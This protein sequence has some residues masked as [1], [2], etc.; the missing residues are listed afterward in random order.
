MCGGT[1]REVLD[2]EDGGGSGDAEASDRVTLLKIDDQ[3]K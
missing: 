3:L 2:A 1:T